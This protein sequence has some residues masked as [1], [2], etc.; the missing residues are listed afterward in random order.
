M[1]TTLPWKLSFPQRETIIWVISLL[2]WKLK[3]KFMEILHLLTSMKDD[4]TFYGSSFHET[5][6]TF[7]RKF[8]RKFCE[9]YHGGLLP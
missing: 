1:K 9:S 2:P 7:H 8:R 3:G 4:G 6:G 5:S